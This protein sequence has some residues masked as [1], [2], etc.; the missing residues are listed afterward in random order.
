MNDMM[1][2]KILIGRSALNILAA[3]LFLTN[4]IGLLWFAILLVSVE[5]LCLPIWMA[6]KDKV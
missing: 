3:I 1:I 6:R 5:L 2:R 4:T